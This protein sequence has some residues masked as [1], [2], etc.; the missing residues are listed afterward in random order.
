MKS[1]KIIMA[2]ALTLTTLISFT[3]CGTNNGAEKAVDKAFSALKDLDFEAAADYMDV[4]EIIDEDESRETLEL[5]SNVFMK[6]IFGKMEH[7][8][9]SS[10]QIDE[11]TYIVK[12]KI[13]AVDMRPVLADYFGKALQYVLANAFT[14]SKPSEE[15]ASKKME[16][17]FIEC[18]SKEDL[19]TVSREVDIEVIKVDGKWKIEVFD[20]LTDALLGGLK[21][22]AEEL[23]DSLGSLE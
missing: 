5:N 10:E 8:I 22:A 12:T 20:D 18:I 17:M 15:E 11:N 23:N 13:T 19:A 21:K 3:G 16:E 6:N 4:D 9:V 2:L 14:S 1:T 7:E